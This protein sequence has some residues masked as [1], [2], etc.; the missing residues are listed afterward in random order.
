MLTGHDVYFTIGENIGRPECPIPTCDRHW[1]IVRQPVV[2]EEWP[3]ESLAGDDRFTTV[4]RW[5][6]ALG[7]SSTAAARSA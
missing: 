7:A 3:V 4:A 1:H 2:L 5:R 6:G